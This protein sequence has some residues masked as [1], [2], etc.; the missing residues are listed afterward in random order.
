VAATAASLVCVCGCYG[1]IAP[2]RGQSLV[3]REVQLSLTDSGSVVLA[4]AIGPSA[5]SI[6]GRIVVDTAATY[7]VSLSS[8]RRRG[9]DETE[10]RGERVLVAR[11]LITDIGARRFSPTRT[12]LFSGVVSAGLVAAR[13][14][15][16]GRGSGG[17][18][19][20][21]GQSGSPR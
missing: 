13:F 19:G 14:A 12:A 18:G 9:G 8:V 6:T 3:G 15:F 7:V 5:E 10:W 4:S 20:G 21:V 11:T 17:G 16:Q 1:Y 2:P